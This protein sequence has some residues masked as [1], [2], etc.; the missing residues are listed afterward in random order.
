MPDNRQSHNNTN[1]I[2][3]NNASAT[4]A[5]EDSMWRLSIQA[6]DDGVD[7]REGLLQSGPYPDRPG[8]PDCIY[9]LRTGLCG[10]GSNCRFNHPAFNGQSARY[11][12]E[13]PERVGQPDCQY[14]LKTGTCKFGVTCKYHHP[15]DRHG[16]GQ[17]PLNVLGLP[18]REEEKSCQYYMRTGSCKFGVACKFNHP[19][20]AALGNMYPVT[21]QS[22]YGSSGSSLAPPSGI[23][24]VGGAWSLPRSP[25]LSS[26]HMQSLPAYMPVG[27]PSSQGIIPAQLG[28]S[29]YTS[30]VSPVSSIDVLGSNS[31]SNAKQSFQSGI[32]A[33]MQ[34]LPTSMQHLPERPDQPECQYFM[35]NGSCKFGPSCKYHHPRERINSFST[36]AL[37]L[38]GFLSDQASRSALT[39]P[40]MEVASMVQAV[41]LITP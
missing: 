40:H 15:H 39:I 35:K 25:Y 23:P 12:G 38:M 8:E 5:L 28:W 36:N 29:T 26:P 24:I 34:V 17:V 6:P 11:S 18:I 27:L 4:D 37:A 30:S 33:Q 21:G 16:A 3:T 22:A 41:N 20:P 2:S 9:Y 13:L 1:S 7:H 32:N 14:F 31:I 10:Y 19:Q